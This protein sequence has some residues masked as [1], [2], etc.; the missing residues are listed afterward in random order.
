MYL[1]VVSDK[2]GRMLY[3]PG[4]HGYC[5]RDGTH[6]TTGH[7]EFSRFTPWRSVFVATYQPHAA[8]MIETD[9]SGHQKH[10]TEDGVVAPREVSR[11]RG[12][13]HAGRL[14]IADVLQLQDFLGAFARL[15]KATIRYVMSVYL[16]VCP[17][18]RMEQLGSHSTDFHEIAI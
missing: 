6:P 12:C 2:V 3:S 11:F 10:G 1:G 16:S 9:A 17:S 8:A 14:H 15:K 13:F 5:H 18:V 7:Q 4:Q